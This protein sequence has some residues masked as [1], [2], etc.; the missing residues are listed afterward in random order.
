MVLL[1]SRFHMHCL[2]ALILQIR[3]T[4][5]INDDLNS[6]LE[7]RASGCIY[8]ADPLFPET[9]RIMSRVCKRHGSGLFVFTSD[10]CDLD[11]LL[12]NI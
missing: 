9:D 6:K 11:I 12:R 8:T 5:V 4:L 3:V 7:M 1:S 10:V 2:F